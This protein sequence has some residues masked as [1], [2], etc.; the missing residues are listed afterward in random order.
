MKTL[1]E[2]GPKFLTNEPSRYGN[3]YGSINWRDMPYGQL[4]RKVILQYLQAD[5]ERKIYINKKWQIILKHDP[6]LRK[7]L[8]MSVLKMIKEGSGRCTN[9]VLVLNE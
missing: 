2:R 6:D 8:K 4:R 1:K 9:S 5:K 7:L 3:R